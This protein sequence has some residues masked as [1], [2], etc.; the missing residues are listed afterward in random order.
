VSAAT[1]PRVDQL[2]REVSF[3]A[4]RGRGPGGQNVN[5]VASAV[6]LTW[7]YSSSALLDADQKARVGAKLATTLNSRGE[8]QLRSDEFRDQERNKARA[9]QKL[10]A[11][12]ADALFI[13]R[14]RRATKPTKASRVRRQDSKVQRSR[15]KQLRGKVDWRNQ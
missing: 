13:P 1:T 6:L 2:A 8:V 9:L 10:A 5:K 4:Q 7:D 12:L 14:A 3:H 11:R 15:T